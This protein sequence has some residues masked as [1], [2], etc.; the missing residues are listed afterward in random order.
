MIE[1]VKKAAVVL[2]AVLSVYWMGYFKGEQAEQARAHTAHLEDI[3][4]LEE[5]RDGLQAEVT[6]I[7]REWAESKEGSESAAR[8]T[9]DRLAESDVRLRV[10]LADAK[11]SE[12]EGYNRGL[13]DG[14]A[15]LHRETAEA[16]IR[17]TQD[18]DRQVEA[19]QKTI[20]EVTR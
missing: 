15:E 19:L 17:I 4:R 13:A 2:L 3:K 10:K 16:L 9:A 14:K 1:S 18:A 11:R 12:V 7:A 8:S 6:K 20:K 5:E